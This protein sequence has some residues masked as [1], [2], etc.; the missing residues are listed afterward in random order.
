MS[1][2]SLIRNALDAGV[3]TAEACERSISVRSRWIRAGR[4]KPPVSDMKNPAGLLVKLMKDP[5]S[6]LGNEV[7]DSARKAFRQQEQAIFAQQEVAEQRALVM[8]YEQYRDETARLLFEELPDGTRV[9]L[10][11]EKIELF[12]QQGRYDKLDVKAREQEIDN[13]IC[14][15]IARREVPPFEKW[16][17]RRRA[18]QAVLPFG[19]D[20][21]LQAV[22]IRRPQKTQRSDRLHTRGRLAATRDIRVMRVMF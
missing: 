19:P 16:Y 10:R 11:K 4:K 5:D 12:R 13:L 9:N 7:I 20:A 21:P 22:A 1:D 15:D 6:L 17:I 8:E 3:M 18:Q 14:H 2:L